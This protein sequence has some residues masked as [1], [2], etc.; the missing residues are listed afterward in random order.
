MKGKLELT[1]VDKDIQ[2]RLEPRVLVEDPE[3]S[4]G[5]AS[6]ENILIFGDNLLSLKALEAEFTGRIKCVCIDPPYNTGAAFSK[7][8]DGLEHSQWL[9]LLRPR[10]QLL[11]A[12]MSL[13]GVIWISIDD[14]EVHYLK[15]LCDEV[16]GRANFIACLPTIMNLKGNQDQF[17]FA[18]AHEYTLVYAKDK[19]SAVFYEFNISEEELAD[20]AVDDIG[21]F[22]KGAPLRATGEEQYREDRPSM[23]YPI[24][25]KNGDVSTITETE[26]SQIYLKEKKQFDDKHL[27]SLCAQYSKNGY[28]VV[29]P[30]AIGERYGRW[31]WGY[32]NENIARLKTD[33][34]VVG[35][36]K[37]ITLYKKQR[38]E[39]GDLPTKKPKTIFYKPEYSSGNGTSQI[40]KLFGDNPF[41]YPKPEELI[42]DFISLSSKKGDWV[43]DSFAGSGTAGAV[44]HKLGRKWIMCEMGEHCHTHIIPRLKSVIG[45]EQG[46]I[47]AG[48][49]WKGGGGFKYY[50]LAESLLVHDKDLSSKD[51]PVYAINPRYDAKTLIRAICKIENFRYRNDGRLHGVSSESRFLHVTT[52]LLTQKYVDSLAEDVGKDQSL[53]IYCSRSVRGLNLPDNIEIKKIPRD[54]LSKCDFQEEK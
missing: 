53:L 19:P 29:L 3:K 15:V 25:V 49:G 31:R 37:H 32:K 27:Q 12:L 14:Y 11:N 1:W 44:A 34:I 16:F 52:Q 6:S 26:H 54:L 18:G 9:S 23:F 36:G 33:V 28:D 51:H 35:T 8:P 4:F 50:R 46:G 40:K 20:W 21:Y 41:P 42:A 47:S 30:H 38:P 10:L 48:I 7:Y 39:L 2:E 22:K 5:N 45:G 13:D 17:A 43:L 24:L